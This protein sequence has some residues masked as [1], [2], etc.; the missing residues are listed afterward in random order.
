MYFES[1]ESESEAHL[2]IANSM[3]QTMDPPEN[4]PLA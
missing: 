3:G 1:P 2:K 4:E